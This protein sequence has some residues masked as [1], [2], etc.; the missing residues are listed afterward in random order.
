MSKFELHE[1]L[2]ADC[3]LVTEL[4]VSTVLLMDDARYP[5]LVLVPRRPGLRDLHQ[6]DVSEQPI[7][8]AEISQTSAALEH[9][10][11]PLKLNV[12]A[13]GNQVPQLHI[14][15]IARFAEDEAWP[16]PV[17]GIGSGEPYDPDTLA[18]TIAKLQAQLS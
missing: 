14:H 7:V 4:K 11:D 1:R 5:W 18:Q 15:V 8:F 13:L 12:A 16:G 2:T 9:L 3:H 17:W 10:Y 6:I